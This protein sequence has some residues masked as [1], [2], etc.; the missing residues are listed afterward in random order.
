[1][2]SFAAGPAPARRALMQTVAAVAAAIF[3][4]GL[5]TAALADGSLERVKK[6]GLVVC[7]VD[8]LLPYSSSDEKVPGFEVEIAKAI[9]EEL[10]ASMKYTWVSWDGL[11]PALTSKRCDAIINGLFITDERKKVIDFSDPYYGSGETILVRKDNDSIKGY[12]DLKGKKTGVL[13]GSVTVGY[14][15]KKGVG[16][17]SIYPD[18]NTI[19]IEL[20]NSRIDAAYLEAPSAAWALRNDPSLNIKIVQDYVPEERFNAGVGVRKEDGE[21][22]AAINQAIAN[23]IKSGKIA[24]ALNHYGVPFFPAK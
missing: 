18:Q 22:K 9:A 24:A 7:G 17:L 14:L 10:G 3:L 6:D 11:I 16:P 1:M 13:A 23:A 2:K 5:S 12:E 15:E 20:N 8:G 4:G 19:I 21:L